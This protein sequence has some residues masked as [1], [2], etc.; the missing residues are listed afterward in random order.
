MLRCLAQRGLEARTA[1]L[2]P[3]RSTFS[4]AVYRSNRRGRAR[5]EPRREPRPE[6]VSRRSTQP[7]LATERSSLYPLPKAG[8]D[9]SGK[10][11]ITADSS[12]FTDTRPFRGA[13]GGWAAPLLVGLGV[14]CVA[15][16]GAR[17]LLDDGDTLSH[18]A[19]GRWIIAHGAIPFADPFTYSARGQGWVPHE[20]LAEVVFAVTYGRL[21]WGGV[22]A[23]AGLAGAA[24]FALLTRA[25]SA[26]LGPRRAA[27]G[28]LAAFALTEAHFLA[29][30][31][32][33][34]W[35]FLVLWMAAVIRTRDQ[36]RVPRLRLLP[37]MVL[38]CNLHGGFVAG[39]FFAGLLAVE[40]ACAA[41]AAERWAAVR[42]WGGFLA[43]ATLA[44]LI[45]PNGVNGL[46]LPFRMLDMRFALSSIS[47]WHAADFSR[48][49]PLAGWIGLL[50]L[51]GLTLGLKLPLSRVLMVLLLLWMALAHV[52]NEELLGI[53]APLLLAASLARQLGPAPPAAPPAPSRRSVPARLARGAALATALAIAFFAGAGALDARGLAPPGIVM[54]AAALAAARQAGLDGRVF[55]SVRFA[56]YLLFEGVPVFVDGRADLF[57]DAFLERYVAATNAVGNWLPKLLDRYHVEWTLLEPSS[58]AVGLL[59]HLAGWERVYADAHAVIHRRRPAASPRR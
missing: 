42:G 16:A 47:E 56:G 23:L 53:I 50:L 21:G 52:R 6:A 10:P 41:P 45:S 38:W 13:A 9:R 29:R 59:D 8:H 36:G 25:L 22:V 18:I 51:G 35:P 57:G 39:L 33:L 30:P 14:Y 49:D 55:N 1:T 34:A 27:I 17:A 7:R 12:T 48:F 19:I 32:A 31:H 58:P 3:G 11:T 2:Q 26:T 37:V 46:L 24:A 20:W 28:A 40:A 15:L 4:G 5:R 54:P 43:L 44:A